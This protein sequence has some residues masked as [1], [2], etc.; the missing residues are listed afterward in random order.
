L[1]G[2]AEQLK[3]WKPKKEEKPATPEK[4]SK[5][6]QTYLDMVADDLKKPAEEK[7]KASKE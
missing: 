2:F 3:P 1:V 6:F 7:K 5:A 4:F